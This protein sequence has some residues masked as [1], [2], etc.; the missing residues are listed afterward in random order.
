M[1]GLIRRGVVGASFFSGICAF[2]RG[3]SV[4]PAGDR[5][6]IERQCFLPPTFGQNRVRFDSFLKPFHRLR[7]WQSAWIHGAESKEEV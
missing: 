1:I 5:D 7:G 6:R 4:G 2:G 3:V